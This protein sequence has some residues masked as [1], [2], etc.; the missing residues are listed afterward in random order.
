MR[1][2]FF[3]SRVSIRL[4]GKAI[5]GAEDRQVK[6][7]GFDR[8]IYSRSQALCIGAGGLIS[9]IAPSLVR[10]GI[11]AVT[12]LD[13][14]R[15]EASNLNR[16]HFYIEDL[17]E[18]KAIALARNLQRECIASTG[19]VGHALTLEVALERGVDL[20]CDVAIC[21]IDNNSGRMAASRYF[22]SMRTAVIFAAVSVDGDHGYVFVQRP[23]GP[24]ICCLY[25]DMINDH[26]FPC[27]GTPAIADILQLV[28]SLAVYAVDS[29][30]MTRQCH[31]NYRRVSLSAGNFDSAQLIDVRKACAAVSHQHDA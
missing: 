11:G 19:I 14:D 12:I 18:R 24:C 4:V 5:P 20:G 29:L 23:D 6:I 15:V 3:G 13:D 28:G 27:P 21:G 26:R 10:K 7:Q 8:Q 22:R 25:P 16:Q 1:T 31:W 9:H 30:L 2:T 17:G